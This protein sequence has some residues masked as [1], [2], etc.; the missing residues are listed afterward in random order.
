V[1][2]LY[3]GQASPANQIVPPGVGGHDSTLPAKPIYDPAAAKGLL[4]RFGYRPHD[5]DGV[6][7]TPDGRPLSVTMS[8]RSGGITRELQT[9]LKKNLDAVGIRVDFH[10]APFQ[11]VI[12]SSA[13]IGSTWT[14]TWHDERR[15]GNRHQ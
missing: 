13:R 8:L 7:M 12:R 3:A 1:D 9:L 6:R 5:A 10:V 2:V 4:D 11:E 14:S 15:A